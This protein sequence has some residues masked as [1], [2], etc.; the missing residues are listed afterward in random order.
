MKARSFIMSSS[1]SSFSSSVMSS[2]RSPFGSERDQ[3]WISH[4]CGQH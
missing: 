4:E 3:S 1:G 2:C